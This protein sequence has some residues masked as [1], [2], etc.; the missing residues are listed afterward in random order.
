MNPEQNQISF[1]PF[2]GLDPDLF[3][4]AAEHILA[5]GCCCCCPAI[6]YE[7]AD[8]AEEKAGTLC[9]PFQYTASIDEIARPYLLALASVFKPE[10]IGEDRDRRMPWW[11]NGDDLHPGTIFEIEPRVLALLL[12]AEFCREANQ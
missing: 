3:E 1:P 8:I 9:G 10:H 7:A 5:F 4:G 2:K 6:E 12:C 11:D